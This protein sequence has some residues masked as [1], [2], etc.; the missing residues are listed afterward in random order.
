MPVRVVRARPRLFIA[1]AVT[2][3]VMA[4][5]AVSAPWRLPTRLLVARVLVGTLARASGRRRAR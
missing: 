4:A 1:G 2:L 3:V 5:L